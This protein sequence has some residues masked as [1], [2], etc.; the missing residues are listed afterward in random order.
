MDCIL[1]VMLVV[2]DAGLLQ[3]S[4][5]SCGTAH[6]HMLLVAVLL[7]VTHSTAE[8][9]LN[10]YGTPQIVHFVL[11]P[12]IIHSNYWEYTQKYVG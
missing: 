8:L 1:V 5:F 3:H 7:E 2:R 9:T 6:C 11:A 10:W 4:V 12:G